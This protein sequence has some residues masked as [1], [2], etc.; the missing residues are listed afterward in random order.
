M[1]VWS[2]GCIFGELIRG[3]VCFPGTD[4]VDQWEKIAIPLGT[5]T[6]ASFLSKLQESVRRYIVGR[7]QYPGFSFEVLFP[8]SSF[9]ENVNE[10]LCGAF[11]VFSWHV[12]G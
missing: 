3:Q 10:K 12:N 1:D 7:P 5:P 9:P 4:Q 2:I 11:I 8:D 6:D